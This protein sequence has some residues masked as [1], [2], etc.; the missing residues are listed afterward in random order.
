VLDLSR[1]EAGRLE[2]EMEEVKLWPILADVIETLEIQAREKGL[3]LRTSDVDADLTVQTDAARLRQILVNVIGNAVKFTAQGSVSVTVEA[4]PG[5]PY[6]EIQV[7]DT[8]I[9]IP[10]NRREFLFQKFSQADASMTRKF[11]GSGLGLVIVRELLEMMGGTVSVD[12]PGEGQGTTVAIS[13]L[14]GHE[15]ESAPAT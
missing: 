4:S 9:G 15:A 14:R 13:V 7:R 5:S 3:E 2:V 8:G 12:S 10:V 11:G 6:V 1:I